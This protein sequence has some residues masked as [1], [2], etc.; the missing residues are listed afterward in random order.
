MNQP[1]AH[2]QHLIRIEP[3]KAACSNCNL[4]ELCLPVGLASDELDRLD[5]IVAKRR[6][7]V[8]G[9]HLFRAGEIFTSLYA[10]R[11]GFFQDLRV[12][13]RRTRT[14]HRFSDGG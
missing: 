1:Q 5:A 10:V 7:V 3:F 11:T 12:G 9:E 4:R 14:G 2:T 8:R 13:R 6:T